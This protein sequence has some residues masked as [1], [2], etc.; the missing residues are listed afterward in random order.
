MD[1]TR[2]RGG[3]LQVQDVSRMSPQARQPRVEPGRLLQ[4]LGRYG[5]FLVE[6]FLR[7]E[8]TEPGGL[9]QRADELKQNVLRVING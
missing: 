7:A 9:L 1:G 6:C 3:N 5:M 8:G 2:E 4:E